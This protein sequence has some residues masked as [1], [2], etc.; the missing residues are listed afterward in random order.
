MCIRIVELGSVEIVRSQIPNLNAAIPA[1]TIDHLALVRVLR[2]S[3]RNFGPA[4]SLCLHE[5]LVSQL[6]LHADLFCVHVP[7]PDSAILRTS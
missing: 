5:T 2:R 1:A 3:D 6:L 7:L 4:G